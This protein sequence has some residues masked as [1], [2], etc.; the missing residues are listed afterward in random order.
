[1]LL[2]E[3]REL[4]EHRLADPSQYRLPRGLDLELVRDNEQVRVPAR[5]RLRQPGRPPFMDDKLSGNYNAWGDNLTKC[6]RQ[7]FGVTHAVMAVE[8]FYENVT[9]P[10]G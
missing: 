1:M 7:Q 3:F 5:Y 2:A 10:D 4:M 8:S 9:G 6:W